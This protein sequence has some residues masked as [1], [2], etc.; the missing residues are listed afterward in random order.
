MYV[1]AGFVSD[2]PQI[3]Q[4]LEHKG[5]AGEMDQWNRCLWYKNE[6]LSLSPS[7][8][9]SQAQQL[10]LRIPALRRQR[11]VPGPHWPSQ[12]STGKYQVPLRDPVQKPRWMSPEEH[13]S[14]V[15]LCLH[16]CAPT[17]RHTR[18]Y[19]HTCTYLHTH[20]HLHTH[21]CTHTHTKKKAKK[22]G[23]FLRS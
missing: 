22:N 19:T 15:V 7:P 11:R 2:E 20:V 12:T 17:H 23:F 14:V 1:K 21:V 8:H 9:D 4:H 3:E 5:R 10:I 16:T 6:D 18:T 13:F